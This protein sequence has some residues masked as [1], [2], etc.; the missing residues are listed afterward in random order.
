MIDFDPSFL[1]LKIIKMD[2]I[3][4]S[5]ALFAMA[6]GLTLPPPSGMN[7]ALDYYQ[8][9]H[10][11]QSIDALGIFAYYIDKPVGWALY[12]YED[13]NFFFRSEIG[14]VCVQIFVLP[15]YRMLGIGRQL[16]Q[17]CYK[18]TKL[19]TMKVYWLSNSDFFNSVFPEN[20]S[21]IESI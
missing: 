15:E 11:T 6:K 12:T 3:V 16:M 14:S 19:D 10:K 5:D 21:N 2:K 9:L 4:S 7:N 1:T 18:R 8:R 20:L 17:W 13:D